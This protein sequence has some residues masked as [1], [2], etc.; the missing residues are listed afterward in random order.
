MR[1]LLV[2]ALLSACASASLEDVQAT[3]ALEV[4]ATV[5]TDQLVAH[6]TELVSAHAEDEPLDCTVLDLENIDQ[7]RRP[8]CHLTRDNARQL[9]REKLEA[10]GYAV[11]L[12]SDDD[13]VFSTSNVVA[14]KKGTTHPDEVVL[15]GAH[16]DAFHAAA[17]DNSSGVAA[18]LEIA[19]ALSGRQT[20]RTVRFVGF[21]LEEFGLVGSTRYVASG[22]ARGLVA[23]VVFD[24][25]GFSSPTQQGLLGFPMPEVGDFLGVI[26]NAKSEQLARELSQLASKQGAVKTEVALAPGT[27]A[28]PMTG[29]LMRSD[30]APFWLAGAPALFLTDTANFRNPHYHTE[31]DHL[32]TLDPDFLARVTKLSTAAVAYWAQ[33]QP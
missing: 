27:G 9:V 15:V 11:T 31:D 13:G 26:A 33:V 12:Q 25:I 28:G 10:L 1:P 23:A 21:D 4:A 24:C 17:D 7:V 19:R 30:H 2:A 18:M 3:R 16:F 22:G 5:D 20:A 14:E 32:D 29:D 6:V 8:V